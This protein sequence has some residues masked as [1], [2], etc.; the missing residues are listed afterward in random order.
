M[1]KKLKKTV[2]LEN[3]EGKRNQ[4]LEQ[5][6]VTTF[7]RTRTVQRDTTGYESDGSDWDM[8]QNEWKKETPTRRK[9]K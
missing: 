1:E 7:H 3:T 4:M 6:T 5:I 9:D 2:K 8:P